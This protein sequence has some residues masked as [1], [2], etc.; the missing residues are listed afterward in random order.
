MVTATAVPVPDNSFIV[1]V[2]SENRDGLSTDVSFPKVV[3]I[4]YSGEVIQLIR[5]TSKQP[6]AVS[7]TVSSTLVFSVVWCI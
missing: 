4:Y 6:I 7:F 2:D 3:E 5:D 1:T